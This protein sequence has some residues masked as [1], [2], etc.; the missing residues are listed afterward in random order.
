MIPTTFAISLAILLSAT[1]ASESGPATAATKITDADYFPFV[2]G[3]TY[4]YRGRESG[5]PATTTIKFGEIKDDGI[6]FSR[7]VRYQSSEALPQ[8][9]E[10]VVR[11][12]PDGITEFR[13]TS[14]FPQVIA[15]LRFPLKPGKK[16]ETAY[17]GQ[18]A[19]SKITAVNATVKVPAGT[20]R[21]C[22]IVATYYENKKV[23]EHVFAPKVGLIRFN[24]HSLV[25]VDG[26]PGE[27]SNRPAK[28]E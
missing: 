3:A 5:T 9:A 2:Q 19:T 16:W 22:V 17:V 18:F 4:T 23:R 10:G 8:D 12:G 21:N 27:P 28:P 15:Q 24:A 6:M 26:A 7:S 14:G 1:P 25:S 13:N 11:S 20:F